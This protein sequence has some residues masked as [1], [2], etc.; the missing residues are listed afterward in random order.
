MFPACHIFTDFQK[1]TT[2]SGY[3]AITWLLPYPVLTGKKERIFAGRIQ[4]S[5]PGWLP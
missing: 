5:I 3:T 2:S 1:I 4:G